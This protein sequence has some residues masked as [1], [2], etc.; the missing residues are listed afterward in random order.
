MFRI[1]L[2]IQD[3][4]SYSTS[5]TESHLHRCC[6]GRSLSSTRLPLSPQKLASGGVSRC[7]RKVSPRKE[8]PPQMWTALSHG[9]ESWKGWEG[10]NTNRSRLHPLCLLTAGGMWPA[11]SGTCHH[12]FPAMLDGII[13]LGAKETFPYV[14]FFRYYRNKRTKKHPYICCLWELGPLIFVD[15]IQSKDRLEWSYIESSYLFHNILYLSH[16][17]QQISHL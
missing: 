5:V 11:A 13:S 17:P 2:T 3:N 7:S 6:E 15:I 4:V 16:F 9:G 14:A 1:H 8:D 10:E 12:D